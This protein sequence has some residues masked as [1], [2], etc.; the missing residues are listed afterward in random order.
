MT[1]FAMLCRAKP[2]KKRFPPR[3]TDQFCRSRQSSEA[4]KIDYP[5]KPYSPYREGKITEPALGPEKLWF[6]ARAKALGTRPWTP[7]LALGREPEPKGAG[8]K[9]FRR[10]GWAVWPF[11]VQRFSHW[12]AGLPVNWGVENFGRVY[13]PPLTGGGAKTL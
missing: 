3:K 9:G 1:K 13:R 12:A 7:F 6:G 2:C 11:G 8:P 4:K 5:R 10:P